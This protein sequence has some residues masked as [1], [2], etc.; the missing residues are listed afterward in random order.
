MGN[1]INN[2]NT[3]INNNETINPPALK[4][5]VKL[6]GSIIKLTN[7]VNTSMLS[8]GIYLL[9]IRKGQE[10]SVKKIRIE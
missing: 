2:K 9:V 4:L 3:N 7:T 6:P 8:S 1:N 5:K 10:Q